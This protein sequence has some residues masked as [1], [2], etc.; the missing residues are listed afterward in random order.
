M[1]AGVARVRTPADDYQV[2]GIPEAPAHLKVKDN[3][4][5]TVE[6]PLEGLFQGVVVGLTRKRELLALRRGPEPGAA[7]GRPI[8]PTP[9]C[10][11]ALPV[12]RAR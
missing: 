8:P 9:G 10:R 7:R 3:V 4:V 6:D 5:A 11:P 12:S 2:L 1:D